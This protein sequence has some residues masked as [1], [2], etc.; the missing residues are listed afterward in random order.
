R[1]K[2]LRGAV[3][4]H[5]GQFDDAR[6]NVSLALTAAAKGAVV[7]N[8]AEV[9]ELTKRSGKLD[10]AV[11]KDKLEPSAPPL[12]ISAKV[13]IN[14]TGPFADAIRRLDEPNVEELLNTSSGVHVVLPAR[15]SPPDTGLLI[16]KTEDGRVLFLL[17]WLGHTLVGTTDNPAAVEAHPQASEDDIEYILRHV[18]QYFD[19]PVERQDVLS[20]WSGLRPLVEPH[21]E[22]EAASS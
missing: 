18:R 3:E 6:M 4:Y 21:H 9:T 2:G 5:D 1:H 12:E 17:P 8:H 15:F 11:I 22:G 19:L 14:A 20:A 7:L 13:V 10:G 16:P